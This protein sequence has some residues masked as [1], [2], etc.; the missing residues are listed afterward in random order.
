MGVRAI[1]ATARLERV[2]RAPEEPAAPEGLP[3]LPVINGTGFSI[4]TVTVTGAIAASERAA[5]GA[6]PDQGSEEVAGA[7]V[8]AAHLDA[9]TCGRPFLSRS[10]A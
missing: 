3:P 9:E 8:R 1:F 10:V 6:G 4:V 2:D 7:C 5:T